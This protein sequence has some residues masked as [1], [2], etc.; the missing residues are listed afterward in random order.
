MSVSGIGGGTAILAQSKASGGKSLAATNPVQA[1]KDYM[2]LTPEQ[3][4]QKAWLQNHGISE[5]EFNAM[6]A[7]EKQAVLDQIK[8]EMMAKIENK[9]NDQLG[10]NV[11][12][13]A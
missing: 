11:N 7:E 12:I 3:K 10:K 9:M 6:S 13:L 1:F 2:N 4:I 5:A 8:K